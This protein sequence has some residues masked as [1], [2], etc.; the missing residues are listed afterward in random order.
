MP[1]KVCKIVDI[2]SEARFLLVVEKEATYQRLTEG[3]FAEEWKCIIVTAKGMPDTNTRHLVRLIWSFLHIPVLALVDGDPY[4][5]D[6]YCQ[7]KYGSV[8]MAY[9][10]LNLTVPNMKLIGLRP[11]D[12]TLC[13]F[14]EHSFQSLSQQDRNKIRELLQRPYTDSDDDLRIEL[15]LFQK[16][17]KKV[18]LQAFNVIAIDYL[19]K[20]FLPKRI[21]AGRFLHRGLLGRG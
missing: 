7:Y 17:R 21:V 19:C 5:L 4:G 8:R 10:S 3:E 2:K 12:F 9:D 15:N 14:N 11:S 13:P 6:I 16:Y 18:E 20:E 1:N